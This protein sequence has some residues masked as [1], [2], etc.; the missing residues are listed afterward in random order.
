MATVDLGRIKFV[1]QGT[2]NASTAYV[3]DDVVYHEGSAYVC[4]LASTGNAPTNTTYW[5]KM[6][7]GSDLGSISGLV[8]GDIVYYNGTAFA[9]LAPGTSGQFLQTQGS[10]ANPQWASEATGKTLKVQQFTSNSRTSLSNVDIYD[11]FSTTYTQAK[12]SSKIR[13]DV[14]LIGFSNSA[15]AINFNLIYDGTTHQGQAIYAYTGQPYPHT[16]T[17]IYYIDGS[18]TTGS[19]SWKFRYDHA[20]S[21]G[22]PFNI[23]NPSGSDDNRLQ[24]TTSTITFTEYDF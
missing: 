5:N 23:W 20:S 13:V 1:W 21:S 10:S 8:Q 6:A 3:V 7:Q 19:K 11:F 9:R 12:A 16:V 17:G 24:Q 18:S 14:H 2:Y 4:I 15:G 22:K